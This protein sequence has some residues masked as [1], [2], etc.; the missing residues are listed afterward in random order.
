MT[1]QEHTAAVVPLRPPKPATVTPLP[2]RDRVGLVLVSHSR[3]L[4]EAT[5]RLCADLVGTGDP[6]PV[7]AAGGR[8]DGGV[9]TSAELIAEAA[10]RADRGVGVAVVADLGSA[11][12]TVRALLADPEENGLPFPIRLADAPFVEGAVA[13]AVTAA[14]GGDLTAVVEAAE[15]A[16]R[17]RKL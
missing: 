7:V 11:V 5:A 17:F 4:A 10:G 6:A 13:A 12:L 9:G 14:A 8:A 2:A 3:D 1:E 15:E 16:Y